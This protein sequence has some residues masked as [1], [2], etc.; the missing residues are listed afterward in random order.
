MDKIPAVLAGLLPAELE[1]LL[2]PLPRMRAVQIYKWIARGISDFDQMTDLP[3]SLREELKSRFRLYSST[4]DNCYKDTSSASCAEKI[5]VSLK[6][7]KKIE[8]VLLRDGKSRFTA[9]LST[10]V[11]CPAGCIFCKTGS[12]GFSRNLTANEITEQFLFLRM[13]ALKEANGKKEHSIDNIVIMGMG[14][15]LLNLDELRKAIAVFTDP[16][17]MNFSRRRIT[18]STCGI[19]EG[20]SDIADNGPYVRLALSLVTADEPLRQKLMPVSAVNSLAKIKETLAV[21]QR[22]GGGRIT[23]ELP[24][25]GGINTREKDA[26]SAAQFAKGIETVVN[27]IPWNP[28]DGLE[29]EGKPL[30]EPEKKETENFIKLLESYGLKVTMRRR[31]GREVMGA[32]G[33]LGVIG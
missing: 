27:I 16:A 18:V 11:G 31:K 8:A 10:Q 4:V 14:E 21:F 23:L 13:T 26:V 6:D 24:L 20:L 3:S 30:R 22:N 9:C 5:A 25:L 17:G 32:C 28:A 2:L 12:L 1:K 7:G 19:C 29:F 15:P 33:Q